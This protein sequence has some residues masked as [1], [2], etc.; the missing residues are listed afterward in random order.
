MNGGW[1]QVCVGESGVATVGAV[2]ADDFRRNGHLL[3][4]WV[5]DYLS[6]VERYPVSPPVE[7]GWVRAQLPRRAPTEPEPFESV[8]ADVERVVV[9]GLTHWQHPSFFAYFPANSSYSSILGELLTAGLG[10]WARRRWR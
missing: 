8:L 6:D 2:N 10:V 1:R 3:V 5:A 4:D 7:P 9:P